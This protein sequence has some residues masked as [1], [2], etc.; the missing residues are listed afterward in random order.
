M[1]KSVKYVWIGAI[2]SVFSLVINTASAA[3]NVGVDGQSWPRTFTNADGSTTIIKQKPQ[4]ILST[5]VSITGTLL[6]IDAPVVASAMAGN[7]E[8]FEQW[9]SV[10]EQRKVE[11]L[12]P[13]GGVD[14]EMAYIYSPDLIVVSTSGA[15]SAY[16]QIAQL[17]Q[18]A[19]TIVLDYGRQSWDQLATQLGEA[20]GREQE[21]AAVLADFE[22][23][24][25]EKKAKIKIPDG[26]VNI[27]SY[28]GAGTVNPISTEKSPQAI[29]LQ[30]L[31]FSIES[32]DPAW[33]TD[34][35]PIRDFVWAQYENLTQLSAPTTF[36][37]KATDKDAQVMLRD[38]ILANVP[39]V[40]AKQVYGL[41]TNSFRVDYYSA[42]EIVDDIVVRF[43]QQN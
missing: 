37:L 1:M 19:P 26:K 34:G 30:Q 20:T 5:S 22:S 25:A 41:G 2:I 9:K 3:I 12:W 18:I 43:G 39:S 11:K 23:Y 36:L 7:G 35:K 15:D 14:L 8:Y 27:V 16:P 31:G 6:S 13:A 24:L 32:A 17:R 29:L 28:F 21:V 40:K 42:K 33:Q 38:P 4:R 10:A